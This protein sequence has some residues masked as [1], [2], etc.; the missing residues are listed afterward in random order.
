MTDRDDEHSRPEPFPGLRPYEPHESMFFFGRDGETDGLVRL[1]RQTRLLAVVGASGSGKSSLVRAGL[2]PALQGGLF[3]EAGSRW[4]VATL[5]PGDDPVGNLAR[6]LAASRLLSLGGGGGPEL[7]AITEA[8]LRQS[9]LGLVD[10]A[11]QAR[12]P[13][14]ENLLVVVE[15][16]EDLF[17]VA[18]AGEAR[19][20]DDASAFC[21]LL[22][23][24]A[25]QEGLP[26]YVVLVL[27]AGYVGDCARFKG[28]P[29]AINRGMHLVSR[30]T[31][32]EAREAFTGPV[33]VR[34]AE[35]TPRLAERLLNDMGGDPRG[36]PA[37]QHALRRTWEA[38]RVEGRGGGP[39][40][41]RHYEA[42]GG[43]GGSLSR[44]AEEAFDELPDDENRSIAEKVFRTLASECGVGRGRGE[45]MKLK[46][47]CAAVG[48]DGQS[49][50]AVVEAFRRE[51]RSFL[52][53]TSALPLTGES[54]VEISYEDVIH[55]WARLKSWVEGV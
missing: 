33:R 13:P 52:R 21:L 1:L 9:S 23:E 26:L 19:N 42:A 5:R 15:R 31:R 32:D 40:D 46:E 11:L 7:E 8:V 29:E 17:R 2:L 55:N 41:L 53:P 20:A 54:L 35:V 16:F 51:G 14:E 28:L 47:L 43:V 37:F 24:A 45:V 34:R 3:A 18:P 4:R 6:S 30:M 44:H 27:R 22:L 10:V 38:W 50:A 36:L 39:L 12:L 49:V 25:E 48:E